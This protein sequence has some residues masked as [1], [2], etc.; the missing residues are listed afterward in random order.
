MAL[1]TGG[2]PEQLNE[3]KVDDYGVTPVEK[4]AGTKTDFTL[5]NTHSWGCSVYV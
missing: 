3:L 1:C 4:F 5:K 2:L